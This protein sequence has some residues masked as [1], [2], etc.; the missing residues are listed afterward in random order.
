MQRPNPLSNGGEPAGHFRNTAYAIIGDR[1]AGLMH[2]RGRT[3]S[4][5][6]I[7]EVIALVMRTTR[8]FRFSGRAPSNLEMVCARVLALSRK[9]RH[10]QLK[11]EASW[12]P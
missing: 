9:V 8:L 4:L 3:T 1:A 12:W 5:F 11:A 2:A 10:C 7:P 6:L